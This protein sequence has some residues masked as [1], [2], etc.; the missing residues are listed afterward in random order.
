MLAAMECWQEELKFFFLSN[1]TRELMNLKLCF[2]ISVKKLKILSKSCGNGG[3][4]IC[5]HMKLKKTQSL[6]NMCVIKRRNN[7]LG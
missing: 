2:N 3:L 1:E 7:S 4:R 5:E 6:E